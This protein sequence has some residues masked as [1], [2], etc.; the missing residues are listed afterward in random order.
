A[1]RD[2]R[3][4][5]LSAD[6]RAEGGESGMKCA[7]PGCGGDVVDGYCDVCGTAPAA[8]APEPPATARAEPPS[9]ARAE[10]SPSAR[11]ARSARSGS[12]R[13]TSTRGRL[14]AG[15]VAMPRVPKGDPAAAIMTNPQVPEGSRFCG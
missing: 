1:R 4:L 12:G 15:I 13:S 8:S 14:G 6:D 9:T 2:P 7:E 11:S 5:R 10:S 3:D